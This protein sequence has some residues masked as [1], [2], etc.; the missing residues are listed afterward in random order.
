M[1]RFPGLVHPNPW[2]KGGTLS[3]TL[4]ERAI[5]EQSGG[6]GVP[7]KSAD[8]STMERSM[9]RRIAA[10]LVLGLTVSAQAAPILAQVRGCAM[11]RASSAKSCPRC[12]LGSTAAHGVAL[13]AGS[14]CRFEASEPATRAPGIVPMPPRATEDAGSPLLTAFDGPSRDAALPARSG[15]ALAPLRSTDSPASLHNTL[16]L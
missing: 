11:P 12:D 4:A 6:A 8:E 16:R 7:G 14:C 1:A 5:R 9:I 10:V 13:S 15:P 3:Y 2:H